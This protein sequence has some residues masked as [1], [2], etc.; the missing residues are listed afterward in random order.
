MLTLAGNSNYELGTGDRRASWRPRVVPEVESTRL[1]QVAC[2]GYHSAAL[3]G[4]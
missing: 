2:G 3:T 4:K 1:T